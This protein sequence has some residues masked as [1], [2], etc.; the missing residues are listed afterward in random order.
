MVYPWEQSEPEFVHHRFVKTKSSSE[1]DLYRP[2]DEPV[3]NA[4]AVKAFRDKA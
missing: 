4:N 3:D 1:H 2:D